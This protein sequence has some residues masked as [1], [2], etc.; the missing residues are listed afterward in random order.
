MLRGILIFRTEKRDRVLELVSHDP[1]VAANRLELELYE[2]R[3]FEGTLP[4][5]PAE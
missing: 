2:W 4:P 5:R 1:S 3:L